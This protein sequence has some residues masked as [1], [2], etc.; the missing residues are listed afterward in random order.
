[1]WVG[2]SEKGVRKIFEKARQAAPTIIFFDEID[3]IA[4]SRGFSADSHVTERVVNLD[5]HQ[6][7]EEIFQIQAQPGKYNLTVE[8][9]T[10]KSTTLQ[11]D[12]YRILQGNAK[13]DGN[14]L[15]II[16]A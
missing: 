5:K 9:L 6:Y 15:T 14:T 2:E 16:G 1:M 12:N 11:V 10:T 4:P 13:I 3:A 7:I 8:L